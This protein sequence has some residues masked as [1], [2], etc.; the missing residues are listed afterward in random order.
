[1]IVF[2][3][4]QDI[5]KHIVALKKVGLSVGFVPTMG[6]LHLGHI[7]L[8][9]RA[10][11]SCDVTVC[12]IFVNPTQ[13]NDKAD[14]DKYPITIDRDIEL[15]SDVGCDVLFLP[16]VKEMYPEGFAN[17]NSVDF[18]FLAQTL[19]GEHRPGHFDGMAQVV[20]RL[21]RI[22]KPHE[23]YMGQKDFQQ[24]L[25]VAE[26]I[27]RR[28]LKVKLIT[29]E[30]VREKDGLAMSS[31]NVRLDKSARTFSVQIS[32]TLQEVKRKLRLEKVDIATIQQWAFQNLARNQ[33]VEVEYFEIR[34][35][36]TLQPVFKKQRNMVALVA[37]RI[38]GVRLIDN[39]LV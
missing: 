20:E 11:K 27:K 26:L 18:G 1:M 37:A 15:L 31:R 5:D 13:F 29:C 33:N 34:D 24:Q 17:K 23:L 14:F 21:L 19:E 4:I 30:T 35:S 8:I 6:A 36:K 2:K 12:S 10:Q 22:V 9:K 3:H 39:M 16:S 32:K 7:S 25:I 28:K 38:G